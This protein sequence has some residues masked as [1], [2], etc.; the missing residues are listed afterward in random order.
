MTAALTLTT[1][2]SGATWDEAY[3]DL[4]FTA[5]AL[6]TQADD[7][8]LN[9]LLVEVRGVLAD[10]E[11]IEADRRR[12]RG[13]AIS[14]RA[15][16]RVAD[17]ALDLVLGK[18][19]EALLAESDGSKDAELYRRFFPEDHERVIAL[20][21]DSELPIAGLAMAQLDQGEAVPDSVKAFVPSMRQCLAVGNAALMARADAYA[22]LGR[23][24]ARVEA[25]LETA[26]AVTRNV[27]GDLTT[28]GEERGLAYRWTAS[29]FS[30]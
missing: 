7:A 9:K 30:R 22:D 29:F 5:F 16:V 15:H 20:G 17:A 21:L 14:A 23:L 28:L 8:A 12:L 6:G 27:H 13:A 1:T 25:W 11:F 2:G 18:L 10:W 3:E 24:Q 19:A 26:D 4:A